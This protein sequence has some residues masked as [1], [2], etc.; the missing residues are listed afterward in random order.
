MSC[1]KFYYITGATVSSGSLILTLNGTPSLVDKSQVVLRFARNVSIPSGATNLPVYIDV[2]GSNYVLLNRF[3][4]SIIG[5]DLI[6][7]ND[8]THYCPMFK[9]L[10]YVGTS[11]SVHFITHN[12]P[13]KQCGY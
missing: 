8:N 1:P 10:T 6:V 2:G 13:V 3:A 9:Y 5:G 12:F 7:A 4:N 11:G